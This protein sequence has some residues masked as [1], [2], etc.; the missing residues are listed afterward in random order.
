VLLKLHR[1]VQNAADFHDVGFGHAV[2]QKMPRLANSIAGSP[3]FL[4]APIRMIG[5]AMLGDFWPLNAACKFWICRNFL[6]R[7]CDEL[8]VTLQGLWA[9]VLFRP[10]KDTRNVASGFRPPLPCP[11][12]RNPVTCSE[13]RLGDTEFFGGEA[14]GFSLPSGLSRT[15]F[16]RVVAGSSG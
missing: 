10:V 1:I 16:S 7:R 14:S 5:S 12:A 13:V 2:N 6:D 8:S 11:K 4:A 9:N 15:P 3:S